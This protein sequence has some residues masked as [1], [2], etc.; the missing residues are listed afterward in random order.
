MKRQYSQL[1]DDVNEQITE[2]DTERVR[3]ETTLQ[4]HVDEHIQRLE[5]Q[6]R[7]SDARVQSGMST[8]EVH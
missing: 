5:T 4:R 6:Q 2:A 8:L 3:S 7:A 1:H